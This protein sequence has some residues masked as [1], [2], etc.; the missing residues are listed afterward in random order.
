MTQTGP[1]ITVVNTTTDTPVQSFL[2]DSN[3]PDI[4]IAPQENKLLFK[5]NDSIIQLQEAKTP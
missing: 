4:Q 1:N 3:T 5:T 2:A